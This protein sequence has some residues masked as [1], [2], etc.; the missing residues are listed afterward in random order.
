MEAPRGAAIRES[1]PDWDFRPAPTP[2]PERT[3]ALAS[4]RAQRAPGEARQLLHVLIQTGEPDLFTPMRW[5]SAST[6]ATMSYFASLFGLRWIS[7][8]GS[9]W[10]ASR[11][12]DCKVARST[13]VPFHRMSVEVHAQIDDRR[14]HRIRFLDVGPGH[15]QLHRVRL[16]RQGDDEQSQENQHDV[17]QPA[18]CSSRSSAR[19]RRVS[20]PL[21]WQY[22]LLNSL[23][24]L[25]TFVAR[26]GDEAHLRN[27][28]LLG[29]KNGA[30]HSLETDVLVG[31]DM[32]FGE[33]RAG[34]G[35]VK[36]RGQE[37]AME[38][39]V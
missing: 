27:T 6:L 32:D 5:A 11:K 25:R 22:Y 8:C 39:R 28:R 24:E 29:R 17:D 23:R 21:P 10:D 34:L 4:G 16:N 18:S 14:R 2:G 3:K 38:I 7:G 35:R 1:R 30:A 13:G 9:A 20:F 36:Q 19:L 37:P 26:F 31:P 15:V 33:R 12:Y